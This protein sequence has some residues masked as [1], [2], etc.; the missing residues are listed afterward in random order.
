VRAVTGAARGT[1]TASCGSGT[2][3]SAL[4]LSCS[5]FDC[6]RFAVEA[7]YVKFG[8]RPRLGEIMR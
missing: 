1:G 4:R 5:L 7:V 2:S 8:P 6:L 3:A